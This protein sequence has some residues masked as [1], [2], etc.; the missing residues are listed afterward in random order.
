MLM[1]YILLATNDLSLL[2]ETKMFLS[3]NFEMNYMGEVTYV[4]GIEILWN[5][6]RGM[7][8]LSKKILYK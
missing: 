6:S 2:Y 7:L 1:I 4:I 3:N 8:S 5:R